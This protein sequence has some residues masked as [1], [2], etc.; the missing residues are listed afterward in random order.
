EL[1]RG[2]VTVHE[3]AADYPETGARDTE[4]EQHKADKDA[5]VRKYEKVADHRDRLLKRVGDLSNH[6]RDLYDTITELRRQLEESEQDRPDHARADAERLVHERDDALRRLEQAEKIRKDHARA[7][8]IHQLDKETLRRQLAS[9]K[10][11]RRAAVS[12]R[13]DALKLVDEERAQS[14]RTYQDVQR[15]ETELAYALSREAHRKQDPYRG[16]Y[17]RSKYLTVATQKVV[18]DLLNAVEIAEGPIADVR[19]AVEEMEG[20]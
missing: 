4:L 17:L 15:L 13:D 1:R 10:E 14:R 19:K 6:N 20:Q 18:T 3:V 9:E 16:G 11:A 12:E 8:A 7:L 5:A 2:T